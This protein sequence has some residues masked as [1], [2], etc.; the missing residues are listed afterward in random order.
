MIKKLKT[1]RKFKKN[2]PKL[3]LASVSDHVACH[4]VW[5][6]SSCVVCLCAQWRDHWMQAVYYPASHV[7]VSI[8]QQFSL[9]SFHDEYSLWF[10]VSCRN[11]SLTPLTH[12]SS[13]GAMICCLTRPSITLIWLVTTHWKHLE[14]DLYST[15][16]DPDVNVCIIKYY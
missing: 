14:R 8:S 1:R 2:I 4:V 6:Q 10:D 9:H 5:K 13:S 11:R 15:R 16:A 7:S 12:L 3:K